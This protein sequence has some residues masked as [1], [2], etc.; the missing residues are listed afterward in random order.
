MMHHFSRTAANPQSD[1]KGSEKHKKSEFL[2]YP[3]G[4]LQQEQRV[5]S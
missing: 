4:E 3:M 1:D 5:V 2:K